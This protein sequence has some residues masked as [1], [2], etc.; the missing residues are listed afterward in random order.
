MPLPTTKTEE[1]AAAPSIAWRHIDPSP[2]AESLILKRYGELAHFGKRIEGC[3]VIVEAPQK[4]KLNARGYSVR[5]T[6][7]LPGPDIT[8][9]YQVAQGSARGDLTLALNR[10]FSAV[11]KQLK[12]QRRT[13]GG[14]EVKHH[15]PVLHGEITELERELGW[16][17]LRADDGREVYFQKDALV[18]ANWDDL[19]LGTRLRFSERI[20]E[21][22][23]FAT[24]VSVVK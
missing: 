23:P 21:K 1:N 7:R 4:R 9:S 6:L 11:E 13:M 5:V 19:A 22:G 16:G 15:D 17:K 24:G 8:G 3:D 12:A 10:A 18:H 2:A 14:V 20:G